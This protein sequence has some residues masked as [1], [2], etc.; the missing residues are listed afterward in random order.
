MAAFRRGDGAAHPRGVLCASEHFLHSARALLPSPWLCCGAAGAVVLLSGNREDGLCLAAPRGGSKTACYLPCI[1]GRHYPYL[2]R[3]DFPMG[4][5]CGS[6]TSMAVETWAAM[7]GVRLGVH[8]PRKRKGGGSL[9]VSIP[10]WLY[11]NAHDVGAQRAAT[12]S[13]LPYT[14]MRG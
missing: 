12:A 13:S 1:S 9:A 4:A 11:I 3:F 6:V 7:R 14:F 5:L 2:R 8:P 10:G